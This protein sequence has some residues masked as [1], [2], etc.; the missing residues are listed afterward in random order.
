MENSRQIKCVLGNLRDSVTYILGKT[1]LGTHEI[2]LTDERPIKCS[3]YVLP[4]VLKVKVEGDIQ[5]NVGHRYNHTC[6]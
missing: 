6:K 2:K 4:H 1:I 3:A 5:K